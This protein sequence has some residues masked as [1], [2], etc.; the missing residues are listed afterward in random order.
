MRKFLRRIGELPFFLS[1]LVLRHFAG[2]ARRSLA[3]AG[4]ALTWLGLGTKG[5]FAATGVGQM[6]STD[7]TSN[8]NELL[9]FLFDA[10]FLGGA[11]LTVFGILHA[12]KAHKGKGQEKMSEA[13][14]MI[15]AGAALSM[16]SWFLGVG[17]GTVFGSG[18]TN[19]QTPTAMTLN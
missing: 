17:Q 16:A 2:V 3:V 14:V 19:A 10:A 9:S 8:G 6:L 18:G 11:G 7:W 1:Y 5:A 15:L 4:I 13:V 12:V